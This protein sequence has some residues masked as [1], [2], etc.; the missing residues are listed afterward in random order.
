MSVLCNQVFGPSNLK[1]RPGRLETSRLPARPAALRDEGEG[2]R[3][4]EKVMQLLANM[5]HNVQESVAY[6]R[7]TG[8]LLE[9]LVTN[10]ETLQ[11]EQVPVFHI[12]RKQHVCIS[13]PL[14]SSLR[15]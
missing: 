15:L 13:G 14:T 6:L 5:T 2:E 4:G 9:R 8:G 11:L 7:H 10:T 3:D 1:A 12:T